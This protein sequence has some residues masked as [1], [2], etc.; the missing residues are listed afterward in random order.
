[1]TRTSR[2]VALGLSILLLPALLTVPPLLAKDDAGQDLAPAE[3][4]ADDYT[5][6]DGSEA[7]QAQVLQQQADVAARIETARAETANEWLNGGP[8]GEV[9]GRIGLTTS[10]GAD[11]TTAEVEPPV[12]VPLAFNPPAAGTPGPDLTPHR[13]G[14][15]G[16]AAHR[17]RSGPGPV[18]RAHRDHRA[19]HGNGARRVD[20][21]GRDARHRADATGS[22]RHPRGGGPA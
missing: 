17:G 20:R 18:R 3:A 21:A 8:E 12:R 16:H 19:G 1:M 11:T 13:H 5:R 6:S 4:P 2:R 22:R 7:N 10:T 15:P 9:L 14:G